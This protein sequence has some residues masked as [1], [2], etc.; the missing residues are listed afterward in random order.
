MYFLQPHEKFIILRFFHYF[1]S[2]IQDFLTFTCIMFWTLLRS[3]NFR[4]SLEIYIKDTLNSWLRMSLM[5]IC[6]L[7][8]ILNS[9]NLSCVSWRMDGHVKSP[10]QSLSDLVLIIVWLLAPASAATEVYRNEWLQIQWLHLS[11]YTKS[12]GS[13]SVVPSCSHHL[14]GA[15]RGVM[16]HVLRRSIGDGFIFFQPMCPMAIKARITMKQ[17][18]AIKRWITIIE[19]KHELWYYSR[20]K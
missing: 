7:P 8:T 3:L 12:R 11:L 5:I 6:A 18:I 13:L 4:N 1:V 19:S 10:E 15:V 2:T 9:W 16:D 17:W 20:F 14:A